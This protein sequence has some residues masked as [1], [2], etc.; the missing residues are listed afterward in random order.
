M[1]DIFEYIPHPHAE[2]R[3][4][5]GPP[6]VAAAVAQLHGPGP[7]GLRGSFIPIHAAER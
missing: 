2:A 6:T 1:P 3:K 4:A 7:I 5:A